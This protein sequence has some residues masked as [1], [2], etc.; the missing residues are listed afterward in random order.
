MYLISECMHI[1]RNAYLQSIIGISHVCS[2]FLL[3]SKTSSAWS[4]RAFLMTNVLCANALAISFALWAELIRVDSRLDVIWSV[5]LFTSVVSTGD[6][7][8]LLFKREKNWK[9]CFTPILCLFHTLR[10]ISLSSVLSTMF[11]VAYICYPKFF[12]YFPY[13]WNSRLP[14][15]R[16]NSLLVLIQSLHSF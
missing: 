8:F 1:A 10:E 4:F 13:G 16:H 5:W 7:N 9:L 14:S 6:N 2:N 12:H 15:K 3:L 11:S